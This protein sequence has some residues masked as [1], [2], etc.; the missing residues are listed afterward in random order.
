M[1]VGRVGGAGRG[2]GSG[3]GR[4]RPRPSMMRT[5]RMPVPI[6]DMTPA[7]TPP[8]ITHAR[9]TCVALAKPCVSTCTGVAHRRRRAGA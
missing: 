7:S 3:P 1:G 4:T 6:I 8:E 9:V 5:L 2:P